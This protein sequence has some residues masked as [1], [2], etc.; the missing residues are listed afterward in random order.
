VEDLMEVE[1][2]LGYDYAM[3]GSD[4]EHYQWICPKCRRS[5]LA[6]AQGAAFAESSPWMPYLQKEPAGDGHTTR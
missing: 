6:L 1:R 2:Q 4:A 3:P 5:M